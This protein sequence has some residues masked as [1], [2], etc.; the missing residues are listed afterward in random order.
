MSEMVITL[1]KVRCEEIT[2]DFLEGLTDEFGWRVCGF[3]SAGDETV[4]L[5]E[6]PMKGLETVA[7]GSEH[8]VNRELARIGSEAWMAQVEFWDEDTFGSD[9]LLGWIEIRRG[10]GP[11]LKVTAGD[12]TEDLGGGAFRLTGCDGDYTV[13]LRIEEV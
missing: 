4:R 1:L 8:S 7:P 3:D 9:D 5:E 10:D 13:W 11:G 2:D 12:T 6:I